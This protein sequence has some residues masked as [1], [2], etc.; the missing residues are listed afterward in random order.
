MI[1][2]FT[3]LHRS[4]LNLRQNA[5]LTREL[6]VGLQKKAVMARHLHVTAFRFKPADDEGKS[7]ENDANFEEVEKSVGTK[8]ASGSS[9][10]KT[11]F[12]SAVKISQIDGE[13]A[14]MAGAK[15][16][17]SMDT[18]D[19]DR[20]LPTAMTL[21]QQFDGVSFRE[22]PV[23]HIKASPNN[24]II[25]VFNIQTKKAL[26]YT[27]ARKEGF[28]HTK[29]KSP[30]AGQTTGTAA[31]QKLLRRGISTVRVV[32]KGIGPG[33]ISSV[34]GLAAAG[35]EVVS[36]SDTTRLPE[37]GPRPKKIRRI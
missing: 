14:G 31:G 33:R 12:R 37:L 24:T 2:S 16:L 34:K 4:L 21:V 20:Q 13:D 6:F 19:I 1:R 22:L 35:V 18:A 9:M 15:S 29:K 27:S 17:L 25:H 36:I 5:P 10:L 8:R 32:V 30:L 11:S 7:V 26:L 3:L 23:V 28:K